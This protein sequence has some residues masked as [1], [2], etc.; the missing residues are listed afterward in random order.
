MRPPYRHDGRYAAVLRVLGP[1]AALSIVLA[2]APAGAAPAVEALRLD[3]GAK[4]TVDGRLDEPAWATA[5]TVTDFFGTQPVEGHPVE[6]PTTVR[7][8]YDDKAVYFSFDCALEEPDDRVRGYVAAREDVN[9]DDQ[10]GIYLDPFGDGRRA[11]IFYV[12]ALGVQQDMLT[13]I[14]GYWSG[15]WDA[16]FRSAGTHEPGRYR[17]EVAIPFRSLRFP[18]EQSDRPWR[19]RFTRRFGASQDK[20]SWPP[21][22]RDVGP[23]LEQFGEL[24]G[25]RGKRAGI[26]LELQ[27]SVV[28][29]TGLDRQGDGSLAWR[30]PGFPET[31]DPSLGI[32]WQISPSMTLDATVNPDF[33]QIEADPNFIDSNLRFPIFLQER[34]PFFLEGIELFDS[35]LLYTRSLVNPLYGLKLSGKVKRY[36]FAVLHSLDETPLPTFVQ[37]RETP[38]FSAE[39]V[40]DALAF[41]TYLGSR[42]DLPGRSSVGITWSDKE[43]VKGG[44]HTGDHHALLVDGI[45]GIDE[46]STARGSVALSDTGAVD[47]DRVR[48]ARGTLSVARAERF[49]G[50]NVGAAFVT[51]GYRAEN[52]F[53]TRTDRLTWS[54]SAN[55]RF[56][57]SAKDVDWVTAGIWMNGSLQNVSVGAERDLSDLGGWTRIR[58]PGLT[59]IEG[60]SEAWHTRYRGRDFEGGA[61]GFEISN[62]GLDFLEIRVNGEIAD[63]IRFSDATKTFLRSVG[64]DIALRALRRLKLDLSYDVLVLGLAG[65]ELDIDQ[66][67]RARLRIGFFQ[68]LSLRLIAQGSIGEELQ[69]SALLEFQPSAGTAVYL[70]WG[71]RFDQATPSS[72]LQT[73]AVDLFLKGTVQIRL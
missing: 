21:Y 39:E 41:V 65:Q 32:K 3:E 7:V 53:L 26:G 56:E 29:R 67:W 43:I 22:R 55:V 64:T 25:V 61:T 48:G 33:S 68:A 73:E 1:I 19:V 16:R 17:V 15:A 24:R 31:V 5:E 47:G 71:H 54:G 27:P 36:T 72:K 10:V 8:L 59:E 69:L 2:A 46:T 18:K 50:F 12:N 52:G 30:K 37:D 13:T 38:G 49:G 9:R 20:A 62:R 34:R 66:V 6:A 63:A 58:L 14:D 28:V 70:G 23:M 40:E 35:H 51:P 44:Q 60:W 4:I 45:L 57:P 42:V 11:Y